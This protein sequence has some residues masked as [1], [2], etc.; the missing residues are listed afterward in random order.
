MTQP[1]GIT[2]FLLAMP[3]P[4]SP[5]LA[6]HKPQDRSLPITGHL[7]ELRRRL[8]ISAIAITVAI[9]LS[10]FLLTNYLLLLLKSRAPGIELIYTSMTEMIGIYM[11][12]S[13]YCGIAL[14]LPFLAYQLIGFISPA[15][16]PKEKKY[17]YLL[18]PAVVV[19]FAGG[20]VFAYFVL[21]PPSLKFL[22]TFGS[23]IA[24]P[25]ISVGSYISLVTTLL[26]WIGIVF[27]LP[28]VITFLSRLGIV[29]PSWLAKNRRYA[30]IGA[31]VLGAIITPTFDPINQSLV[32][33]PLIFLYE[34]GYWLGRL[35]YKKKTPAA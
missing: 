11:K 19:S 32:A 26:F 2:G 3:T 1:L 5:S 14:S 23:N 20:V 10:L 25:L 21:L 33:I 22:L 29:N 15:L 7:E 17:V 35:V 24:R 8:V 12:V 27:Q 31:F 6:P 34:I 9:G 28:L 16:T 30:I 4:P 18:L 13:L